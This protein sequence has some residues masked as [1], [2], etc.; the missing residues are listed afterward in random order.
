MMHKIPITTAISVICALAAI[1][2]AYYAYHQSKITSRQLYLHITPEIA[3]RLH[4]MKKNGSFRPVFSVRNRSPIN[5]SSVAVDC[6]FLVFSKSKQKFISAWSGFL[7]GEQCSERHFIYLKQLE[8]NDFHVAK[9]AV[10]IAPKEESDEIYAFLV[11]SSYYRESDMKRFDK[12]DVYFF[13]NGKGFEHSEF[14]GHPD[15]EKMI[16]VLT[17]TQPPKPSP[18]IEIYNSDR[19]KA[20]PKNSKGETQ[21]EP[22]SNSDTGNRERSQEAPAPTAPIDIRLLWKE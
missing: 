13:E 21:D 5:I 20:L 14:T 6:S 1:F 17:S 7:S 3:T 11:F 9:V 22:I 15:Y 16:S 18:S 8:P 2:S 19:Y 10:E 4:F 12:R